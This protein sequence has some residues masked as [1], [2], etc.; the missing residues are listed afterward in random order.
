MLNVNDAT[1]LLNLCP[2]CPD[3]KNKILIFFLGY[4]TI[5]A[6]QIQK[7][8]IIMNNNNIGCLCENEYKTLWRY[9]IFNNHNR[10]FDNFVVKNLIT[11]YELKIAYLTNG[12]FEH[13]RQL[14]INSLTGAIKNNKSVE[15]FRMCYSHDKNYKLFS[16]PTDSDLYEFVC[17]ESFIE[18]NKTLQIHYKQ[19][20]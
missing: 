10:L 7:Q 16:T 4:G 6:N 20:Y 19:N 11:L 9:H 12:I 3:I 18:A 8:I 1:K 5:S 14:H 17:S 2:I 13:K 15:L